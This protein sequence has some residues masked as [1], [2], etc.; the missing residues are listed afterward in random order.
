MRL[1]YYCPGSVGGIADY[2]HAQVSSLS[3]IGVDVTLLTSEQGSPPNPTC[4]VEKLLK[5]EAQVFRGPRLVRQIRRSVLICGNIRRLRRAIVEG[6]FEHVLFASYIEYAAPLWSSELT[7]LTRRGVRFAAILHDPIRDYIAGPRWWHDWSIG[8]G[9]SFLKHVFVHEMIDPTEVGVPAKVKI[10]VIPHG[11][12]DFPLPSQSREQMRA[13]LRVPEGAKLMLSFGHIRDG[14]N[15][16][17]VLKAMVRVPEVWL[18]VAGKEGGGVHRG[19]QFYQQLAH[20]LGVGNRCRWLVGHLKKEDVGSVFEA[21]D[22]VIM[23]YSQAFRS[24]SGVLNTAVRFRKPSIASSGPGPLKT[25]IQNFSLGHWVEPDNVEALIAGFS[26]W[27]RTP[28]TPHWEEYEEENSWCR[29]AGIVVD[30]FLR[31]A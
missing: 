4:V 12:Y 30:Q 26:H 28:P 23:A 13:Q 21:S 8:C 20:D 9:Y 7:G 15:L 31:Q 29:N 18:L 16:D 2:T 1:A 11:P 14:K 3:D 22:V 25:Q 5:D 24:A 17:L 19:A 27:L 6:G 10:T